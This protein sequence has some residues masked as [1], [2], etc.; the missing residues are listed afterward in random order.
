MIHC[1]L[2]LSVRYV[3]STDVYIGKIFLI[4]Y[5]SFVAIKGYRCTSNKRVAL[6]LSIA[7]F[8]ILS[9]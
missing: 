3:M 6:P 7:L 2:N 9:S 1:F 4:V 5:F 8:E